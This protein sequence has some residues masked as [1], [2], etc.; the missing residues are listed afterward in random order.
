[1]ADSNSIPPIIALPLI[2]VFGGLF[3][4]WSL[5]LWREVWP[6]AIFKWLLLLL[7]VFGGA[8]MA[9]LIA[10]GAI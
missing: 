2:L 7:W 5:D 10:F 9:A 4:L 6:Y 1:M 3:L 8:T